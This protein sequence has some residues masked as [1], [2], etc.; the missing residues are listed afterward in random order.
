MENSIVSKRPS[1]P[2]TCLPLVEAC[3]THLQCL[4]LVAAPDDCSV[5][6]SEV[7][8]DLNWHRGL[9]LEDEQL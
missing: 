3:V 7:N 9:V 6:C 1:S 4:T 5:K 8:W 2:L